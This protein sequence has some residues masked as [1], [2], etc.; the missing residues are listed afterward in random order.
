MFGLK[1]LLM[2]MAAVL[3]ALVVVLLACNGGSETVRLATEGQYHP[4]NFINDDGEIDGL[5]REVGDELCCRAKL[6]CEWALNEWSD[7]IPDL[8]AG[9]LTSSSRG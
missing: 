7:M 4:F 2:V 6:D 3:G 9:E 8:V 1:M 5:E